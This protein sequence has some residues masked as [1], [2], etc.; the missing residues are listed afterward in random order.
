MSKEERMELIK[1]GIDPMRFSPPKTGNKSLLL[2]LICIAIGLALLISN[3][4]MGHGLLGQDTLAISLMFLLGLFGFG[5]K[6]GL[7]PLHI[8]LPGA[9]AAAPSHASAL[10]SGVMIKTGIYGLVR[11]TSFFA[12]I[13]AWWGWT[14]MLLGAISGIFGVALA[15]AQ[16]DIKR[17]LAYHSVENIGI[18]ALGLGLAL[19]GRSYDQPLLVTLGLSSRRRV[20]TPWHPIPTLVGTDSLLRSPQPGDRHVWT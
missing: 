2:G 11:F 19:L 14:F 18:I 4:M 1:R 10:L 7:M 15:I 13:P 5:M 3:L 8:W 12:E 20:P 16:H 9:H 17:L 6:S